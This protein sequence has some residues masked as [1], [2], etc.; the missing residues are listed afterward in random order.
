MGKTDKKKKSK[1]SR[2]TAQ[3][4]GASSVASK[5][6]SSPV[7]VSEQPNI[8]QPQITPKRTIEKRP[9]DKESIFKYINIVT[10]FFRESKSELKKVKWPTRK[11]LL[12]ATVMVIVLVLV[13]S[14]Y[15]GLID[16]GLI[17]IIKLIVG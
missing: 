15:L 9:E 6:I 8:E 12:A 10:Q 2:K 16:F 17:K 3:T 5:P 13:V 1:R 4:R 7:N 11:E 14:F